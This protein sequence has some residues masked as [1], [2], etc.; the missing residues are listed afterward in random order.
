[1]IINTFYMR[2]ICSK[3]WR[4]AEGTAHFEDSTMS[5]YSDHEQYDDSFSDSDNEIFQSGEGR[6]RNTKAGYSSFADQDDLMAELSNA[7]EY[8]RKQMHIDYSH[9]IIVLWYLSEI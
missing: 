9:L 8:V 1:M 5:Q 4:T 7:L 2:Y 6:T 3:N